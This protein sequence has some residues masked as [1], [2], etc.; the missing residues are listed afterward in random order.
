MIDRERCTY[1]GCDFE[2]TWSEL[3]EH[4][5]THPLPHPDDRQAWLTARRSFVGA[6]EVPTVCG[7]NP[8]KG[9]LSVY[10]AKTQPPEPGPELMNTAMRLGHLFEVP[11]LQDYADRHQVKIRRPATMRM[12]G[13]PH[14]A[15]TPDGDASDGT[16]VQIKMVGPRV[17]GEWEDGLPAYVRVQVNTEMAVFKRR[18]CIVLALVGGTDLQEYPVDYDPEIVQFAFE[19]VTRFW[20][21]SIIPRV[22]P[23]DLE[24]ARGSSEE[25]RRI[26]P[27]AIRP[28]SMATLAERDLAIGYKVASEQVKWAEQEQKKL[29]DQLCAV[30]ADREG[31]TWPKGSEVPQ[32]YATWKPPKGST[33]WKEVA[34]AALERFCSPE[35]ATDLIAEFTPATGS[36]RLL[37]NLKSK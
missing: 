27:A 26:Y 20:Q 37:V 32:G 19:L 31:F 5:P 4:A 36:R 16:L 29:H 14:I 15:A 35:E 12:D 6:S 28:L 22:L 30:I 10:A 33:P 18:R 2:G 17:A 34:A 24:A 3:L 1:A 13:A 25:L 23:T 11:L 9:S 21:E 8:W 7:V